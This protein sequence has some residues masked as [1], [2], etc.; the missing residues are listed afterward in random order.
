MNTWLE[1]R[2]LLPVLESDLPATGFIVP[3]VAAAFIRK[4]E[5]NVAIMDSL[6][7]N[8]DACPVIRHRAMDQLYKAVLSECKQLKINKI[9]G[10]TVNAGT[11]DRSLRHGFQVFDCTVLT[12]QEQT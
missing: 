5:G 12:Y 6:V 9:L 1:A 10:F 4:C 3:G 7:S 8:K 2:G 11:L